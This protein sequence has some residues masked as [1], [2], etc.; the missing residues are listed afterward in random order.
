MTRWQYYVHTINTAGFFTAGGVNTQ[1]MQD[2]L[3][4]CGNDGWELVSAFDT[5]SRGG[6]TWLIVLTFKRPVDDGIPYANPAR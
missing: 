4:S 6:G 1:E 2:I 3:N 5:N